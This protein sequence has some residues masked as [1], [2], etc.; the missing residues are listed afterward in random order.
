[1]NVAYIIII[2]IYYFIPMFD[3]HQ[4]ELAQ[5]IREGYGMLKELFKILRINIFIAGGALG[6]VLGDSGWCCS[7]RRERLHND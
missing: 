3:K 4:E 5:I 6:F 7:C 2:Y 1:M